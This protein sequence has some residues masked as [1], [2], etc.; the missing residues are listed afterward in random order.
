LGRRAYIRFLCLRREEE[1]SRK[2][3]RAHH[4]PTQGWSWRET[5]FELISSSATSVYFRFSQTPPNDWSRLQPRWRQSPCLSPKTVFFFLLRSKKL[6]ISYLPSDKY[7][8]RAQLARSLGPLPRL[9]SPSNICCDWQLGS[10]SLGFILHRHLR[11][12][13]PLNSHRDI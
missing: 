5:S 13:P 11:P 12:Q 3:T 2:L 1:G 9:T 10:G 8:D 6:I 7:L 4:G